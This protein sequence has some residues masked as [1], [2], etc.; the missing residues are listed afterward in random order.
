[1]K[2]D[3]SVL[4]S[5]YYKER[6]EYLKKSIESIINQTVAPKEIVIVCFPVVSNLSGEALA[7]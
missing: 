5:V 6:P 7:K 1:M 4:M 3:F 2:K